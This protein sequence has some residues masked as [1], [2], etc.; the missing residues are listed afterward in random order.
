MLFWAPPR[1][2]LKKRERGILFSIRG[3]GGICLPTF[4]IGAGVGLFGGS[5]L[6]IACGD[7][8]D[9]SAGWRMAPTILGAGERKIIERSSAWSCTFWDVDIQP[10]TKKGPRGVIQREPAM[11]IKKPKQLALFSIH[12]HFF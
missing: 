7:L 12:Q 8:R 9:P 1:P 10:E 5:V 3:R 6:E 11:K 4:P 2:L